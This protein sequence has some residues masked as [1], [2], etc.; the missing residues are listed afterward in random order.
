M[1]RLHVEDDLIGSMFWLCSGSVFKILIWEE[2][3]FL[4]L[5]DKYSLSSLNLLLTSG[6]K[7]PTGEMEES[8]SSEHLSHV[9]WDTDWKAC[10]MLG[11]ESWH[12][13]SCWP[14]PPNARRGCIIY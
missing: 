9:Q 1:G 13:R 3:V 6:N 7:R 12:L 4:D 5:K 11:I 14:N 8:T 2:E 10:V